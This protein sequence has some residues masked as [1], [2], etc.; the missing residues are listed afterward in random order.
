MVSPNIV[1]LNVRCTEVRR[2]FVH[3]TSFVMFFCYNAARTHLV[4]H[5]G[6]KV[7]VDGES[8]PVILR[9][10]DMVLAERHVADGEVIKAGAV[11]RLEARD[12]DAGLGIELLCYSPGDAVQLHAVELAVCHAL[13]KQAEEVADTHRRL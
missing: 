6:G 4:K 11:H 9:V 2:T 8:E 12:G 5:L 13:G 3:N 10:V 7:V 1:P